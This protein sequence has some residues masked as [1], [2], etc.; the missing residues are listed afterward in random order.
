[1][2]EQLH[3][4]TRKLIRV[5]ADGCWVWLGS[6]TSNGYAYSAKHRAVYEQLVGP[7]PAG[8]HLDHLCNVRLCL[9]PE[10]LEPVT[11]AE[12][13][14]RAGALHREKATHCK[15]GH[16]FTEYGFHDTSGY[17]RCRKCRAAASA[18]YYRNHVAP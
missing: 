14:R 17:R 7:I 6:Q 15:Q 2:I 10:H 13:N 16:P 8:L 3:P 12:N 18:R 11:Q 4:R 1:M 5:S 9:N